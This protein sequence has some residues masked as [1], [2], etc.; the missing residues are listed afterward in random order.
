MERLLRPLSIVRDGYDDEEDIVISYR[1]GK[2]G[3]TYCQR[4]STH[5][6]DYDYDKEHL[7]KADLVIMHRL[8]YGDT[9][10]KNLERL[11]MELLSAETVLCEDVK[12]K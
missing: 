10:L 1:E 6:G 7:Q 2:D 9:S 12:L 11:A 3:I 5:A 4:I 8:D